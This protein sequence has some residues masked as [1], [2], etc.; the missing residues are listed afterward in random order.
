[1]FQYLLKN[2]SS[3]KT[4][5]LIFKEEQKQEDFKHMFC[6][7]ENIEIYNNNNNLKYLIFSK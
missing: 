7:F 5:I 2:K 4:T 3:N 6:L 1:M